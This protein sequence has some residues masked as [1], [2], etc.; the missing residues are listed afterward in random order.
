MISERG[1][2]MVAAALVLGACCLASPASAQSTPLVAAGGFF[3]SL[4]A[5]AAPLLYL[6]WPIDDAKMLS[7]SQVGWTSAASFTL[8]ADADLNWQTLVELTP[9]RAHLSHDVYASDGTMRASSYDDTAV[10]ASTGV[11]TRPGLIQAQVEALAVKHWLADAD[12]RG[13]NAFGAAFGGA[14]ATILISNAHN[15]DPFESIVDGAKLALRGEVLIGRELL[16]DADATLSWGAGVGPVFF[17]VRG[18]AFYVHFDTPATNV[19]IGGSW[20]VLAATALWGYALGAFRLQQG[21]ASTA[22]VD[23]DLIGPLRLG[24]R[25]SLLV[26][27]PDVHAGAGLQLHAAVSGVHVFAAVASDFFDTV[28]VTGGAQA[29]LLFLP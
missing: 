29:A 5:T 20:D 10:R 8:E 23:V 1:R 14:Q 9:I 21:A 26:G 17:H 19:L 18:T 3:D 13:A 15:Y 25:G 6:R 12:W 16:A 27:A 4:S 2:A 11:S 28:T 7:V 22:G 24:L